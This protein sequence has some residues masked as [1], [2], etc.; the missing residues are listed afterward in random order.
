[1]DLNDKS[2]PRHFGGGGGGGRGRG[3]HSNF[4]FTINGDT[5]WFKSQFPS[6]KFI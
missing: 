1:M 3:F 4:I 2:I 5:T 6:S